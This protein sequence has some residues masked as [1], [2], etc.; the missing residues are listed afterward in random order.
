[1][2]GKKFFTTF[3]LAATCSSFLLSADNKNKNPPKKQYGDTP[4]IS[5]NACSGLTD[6][7]QNFAA[8]LNDSNAMMFCSKMSPMQRQKAMQMSATGGPAGVPRMSPD[9]SVQAVMQGNTMT[10]PR[11]SGACPVQ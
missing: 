7:E 1:M 9:D 11:G 10:R 3:L 2:S 5:P 6:E 4:M 8:M